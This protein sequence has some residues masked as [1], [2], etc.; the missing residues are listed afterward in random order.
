M[1]RW[2]ESSNDDVKFGEF[3]FAE[4]FVMTESL[5]AIFKTVWQQ[6]SFFVIQKKQ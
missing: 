1:R 6:L 3:E 5:N 4:I 2:T